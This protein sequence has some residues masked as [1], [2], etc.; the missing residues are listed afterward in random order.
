[1]V[2]QGAQTNGGLNGRKLTKSLSEMTNARNQN[3]NSIESGIQTDESKLY[4]V[5][6][7]HIF[8]WT[9]FKRLICLKTGHAI[10][11]H[12]I[13]LNQRSRQGHRLNHTNQIQ[14]S[15]AIINSICRHGRHQD[16][17]KLKHPRV[18]PCLRKMRS[19]IREIYRMTVRI[20]INRLTCPLHELHTILVP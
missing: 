1:M 20:L 7:V 9:S 13:E 12:Y 4:V 8:L 15:R 16:K 2:S 19:P 5:F 6:Y 18:M 17:V 3:V 10:T 14:N 11:N